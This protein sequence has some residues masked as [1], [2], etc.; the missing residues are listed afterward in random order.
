MIAVTA[1]YILQ[2]NT[3]VKGC[4]LLIDKGKIQA[5][6]SI[7]QLECTT[8]IRDFGD[9]Y[10]A[11]GLFD[12]QVNGG[13]DILLNDEPTAAGL[14]RIAKAHQQFGTTSLLPTLITDNS[15]TM[16]RAAEAVTEARLKGHQQIKGLHFEGPFLNMDRKGVHHAPYIRKAERSFLDLLDE[17][18]LGAVLVTLA[19]EN[20]PTDFIEELLKRDVIISMGHTAA[21][22]KIAKAAINQGVTGLT[23]LFNAMP[24]FLS[25]EPGPIGVAFED[26]RTF[27]SVIADGH[28]IHPS[29]LKST[30][31]LLEADRAI[32]ITDAMPPVGGNQQHFTLMDLD[33]VVENGRC[34]TA[35]GTLAGACISMWDAIQYCQ[36]TLGLPLQDCLKMASLTPAR[37]MGLDHQI[38]KLEAGFDADFICFSANTDLISNHLASEFR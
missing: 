33:V 14:L 16:R 38:G 26:E 15:N 13:G 20:V 3:W 25:R 22:Y 27:A 34:Q 37:F 24:P 5:V 32:L 21:D 1:K 36:K 23:H 11:P 17:L 12:I 6:P 31:Q 30:L 35:D 8:E 29:S 9:V 2:E 10:L 4:A 7:D 18:D 28:H 19:P